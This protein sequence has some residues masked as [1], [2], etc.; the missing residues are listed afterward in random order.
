MK[1][2]SN[3]NT[4]TRRFDMYTRISTKCKCGHTNQIP[5]HIGKKICS[6]CGHWVYAKTPEGNKV[7]FKDKLRKAII[8]SKKKELEKE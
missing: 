7:E 5:V 6:Y 4:D 8:W 3:W 1:N 2:F